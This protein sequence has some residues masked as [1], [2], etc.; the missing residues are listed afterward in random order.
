M[1]YNIE[2]TYFDGKDSHEDDIRC[3][4]EKDK[5][6]VFQMLADGFESPYLRINDYIYKRDSI[7]RIK[8]REY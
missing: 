3:E 5:M 2:V 8:I 4:K 1:V 7:I 6:E